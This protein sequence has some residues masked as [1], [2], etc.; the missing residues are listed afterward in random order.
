MTQR[1]HAASGAGTSQCGAIIAVLEAA[2]GAWVPMP[3]LAQASGAY[4]VHSRVAELRS[5]GHVIEQMSERDWRM[6]RS[7]YRLVDGEGHE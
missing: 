7:F 6:V 5:W 2:E 3:G 1:E 4:A